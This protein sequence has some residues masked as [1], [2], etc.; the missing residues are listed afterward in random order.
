MLLVCLIPTTGEE[1]SNLAPFS[2]GI[3]TGSTRLLPWLCIL[4]LARGGECEKISLI[5]HSAGGW[6]ARLYMEQFGHSHISLLL[7]LGSPHTPPPK[8]LPG[9]IDQTRGIL[10]YVETHCA[11]AVYAPDSL[12]YVCIAGRYVKGNRLFDS[13]DPNSHFQVLVE[14][15]KAAFNKTYREDDQTMTEVATG[16]EILITSSQLLRGGAFSGAE[17]VTSSIAN[18]IWTRFIGQGYKQV[19]GQADVWGDGVVPEVSARLD[20]ALNIIIDGVYHSPVGSDD[21]LRPWY[22]SPAILEQWIPHLLS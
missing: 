17:N 4:L 9:V 6:L 11:R 12:R 14:N 18:A 15:S 22:G 8:G 13:F 7:T 5:G 21:K 16:E 1:I 19:C 2:T 20:G 10:D 3:S